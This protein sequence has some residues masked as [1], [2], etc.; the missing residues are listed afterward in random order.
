VELLV[1]GKVASWLWVVDRVWRVGTAHV[2]FGG[3]GGVGTEKEHRNKG[4]STACMVKAVE[5]I[6]EKGYPMTA[7]FGIPNFYHRW[8]Y[9]MVMPEPRLEMETAAAG[10]SAQVPGHRIAP[11]NKEDHARTV[12]AL[13]EADNRARSAS[14]V[15]P[16]G[17]PDWDKKGNPAG[18]RVPP[19]IAWRPFPIGSWWGIKCESFVVRDGRG[20]VI[21]YAAY[22]EPSKP[23][24][25]TEVGGRPEAFP[26]ITAELARRAVARKA[27]K[28]T[29]F[30]PPD[31]AYAA[32]LRRWTV[33]NTLHYYENADGMGRIILL[34][35]TLAL[36]ARDLA[37]RLAR[38][39]LRNLSTRVAFVTDI[40]SATL[41]IRPGKVA[42]V[43][44]ASIAS[45]A[46][47]ARRT[48]K[49]SVTLTQATTRIRMPQ[50]V[51]T[52]LLLGYREPDDAMNA[53]GVNVPAKAREMVRVM[54]PA[55]YPYMYSGDRY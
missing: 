10:K 19:W 11:F 18:K 39:G 46:G 35:K 4:Y 8:G 54:F 52:Q 34:E 55:G 14:A 22:D 33:T 27:D 50:G 2:P 51:L 42:V 9:A 43:T 32:Y 29:F 28:L 5:F 24:N 13:Y 3:I 30:V 6:R 41:A 38:S 53:A 40:G 15:R 12:L 1:A 23:M 47:A 48:S 26:S 44:A 36:C 25:V 7:L 45:E 49:S 21:G 31:H 20:R 17:V 16:G 37:D